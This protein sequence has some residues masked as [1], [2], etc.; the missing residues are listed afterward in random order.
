MTIRRSS[1]G[2]NFYLNC[3]NKVSQIGMWMRLNNYLNANK[4]HRIVQ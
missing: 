3:E 1:Y 4:L 2:E